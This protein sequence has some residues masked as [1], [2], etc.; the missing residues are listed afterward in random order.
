MGILKN[1]LIILILLVICSTMGNYMIGNGNTHL[2]SY[3]LLETVDGERII[4]P[5]EINSYA[6]MLPS[7]TETLIDLG[8]EDKIVLADKGS[9]YLLQYNNNVET[10]DIEKLNINTDISTITTQKPDIILVDK[11]T[12]LKLSSSSIE[13]IKD[14]GSQ[15]IVLPVPK[16]IEEIRDELRFLVDLT[17]AKY[18]D[19]LLASFDMKYRTIQEANSK[20][21]EPTAV[22]FQIR[23]NKAIA[24]CGHDTYINDMIELAGGKNVFS[25][26]NGVQYTS[27]KEVAKRNPQYY[28]AISNDDNYQKKYIMS[29]VQLSKIDAI[30][31]GNV[32]ILDHYQ[33]SNP[34]HRS[35]DAILA[36]GEL[37]HRQVY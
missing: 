2:E 6:T 31:G 3:R 33:T 4:V 20:I 18:G 36:L 24:T 19:K 26:R 7:Y 15:L 25:D 29:D 21:T 34:N 37:L 13:K 12:Y 1:K 30:R 17:Q 35:L 32:Y 8:L 16:N 23:D 14:S 5:D 22:F 10:I 27:F 28:I 11:T 9:T